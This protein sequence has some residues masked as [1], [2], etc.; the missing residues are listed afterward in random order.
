MAREI[1]R[2]LADLPSVDR[3]LKTPELQILEKKYS[4]GVVKQQVQSVL[5]QTRKTVLKE[6]LLPPAIEELCIQVIEKVKQ[7]TYSLQKVIN[8]TGT[9]LHTNLGRSLLS[10]KIEEQLKTI[11]FSYSNLEMDLTSGKR[12][13]RYNHL[14]HILKKLTG[15]EDVLVV[16]NNA[17][18]I[19]LI[20]DTL[21]TD[22]EVL[23]SRGE[24]VE[25][26]GSFR[27]PEVITATGG[28]IREVG[29]T[30]KTHIR[31][32]QQAL[33][34]ETGAIL[35]FHTSNYRIIGFTETPYLSELALLAQK[36]QVPLINDLGS[37]L[38]IDMRRFGLPYEPTVRE[39][40]EQGCD[41]VSFS[42]DKLLGGPQAGIIVGKKT[43]IQR[44]KE[45][46]LL[47]ALRVD[48][49]T[50]SALEATLELYLDE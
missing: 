42:G 8:G 34:S 1:Q 28:K 24:L 14:T 19:M 40:I 33:T 6:E 47:R 27:I 18:A 44:M 10:K 31:D 23:V 5:E 21:A 9:I 17:A 26:G 29:T 25:I 50:L 39:V 43:Y 4:Y 3:L 20:L 35:K 48:K 45:N 11:S 15:A 16:N 2:R 7:R 37:G 46:Q 38:L 36:H 49:M 12:G 32:Y 22:K 41:V 13:T 30:N